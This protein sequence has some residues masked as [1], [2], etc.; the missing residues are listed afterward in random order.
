MKA[1]TASL[2][3]IATL[4]ILPR[5]ASS[6]EFRA[7]TYG[8]DRQLVIEG[9]IEPGDSKKFIDAIKESQ[10]QISTVW[11]FSPGGDFEEAMK[12]GRTMRALQLTSMVP[13][14]NQFGKPQCESEI[15]HPSDPTNC[16]AASAAFMI[17]IG[18][19]SRG[20]NYIIVHRPYFERKNYRRLSEAQARDKFTE[21][22]AE[23]RSYMSEMGVPAHIQ[24]QVLATPS[25]GQFVLDDATVK[26]YF[27][28][29]LPARHEWLVAQCSRMSQGE[30]TKLD[31]LRGRLSRRTGNDFSSQE[32][33]DLKRLDRLDLQEESCRLPLAES[34]RIAAF[35]NYFQAKVD[36][37]A[38]WH[39]EAW[40]S[41]AND[42]GLQYSDLIEKNGFVEE[43]FP[44]ASHLERP[45]TAHSPMVVESDAP[46]AIGVVSKISVFSPSNPSKSYEDQLLV[47]LNKAWGAPEGS[48]GFPMVWKR[49]AFVATLNHQTSTE[50]EALVLQIES[51]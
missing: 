10:G 22:Q 39:F 5:I 43:L 50:G 8:M 48:P 4:A 3:A 21:L 29:D 23:A 40:A 37:H 24:E 36:A 18:G 28:G 47:A 34:S 20:G 1:R 30:R 41:A 35:E 51:R 45:A 12:I 9:D 44:D 16:I 49:E 11:I 13:T 33:A 31:L 14:R 46:R 17:H 6:A 25:D 7:V 27:S 26:T 2:I 38:E 15:A 19:V 32:E 42:L